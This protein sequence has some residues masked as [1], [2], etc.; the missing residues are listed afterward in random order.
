MGK[1]KV[2]E[3]PEGFEYEAAL[4]FLT[5]QGHYLFRWRVDDGF[6]SKFVRHNDVMAAVHGVEVDSGWTDPGVMRFGSDKHGNWFV[7]FM[8]PRIMDIPFRKGTEVEILRVPLPSTL[9]IGAGNSHYM[10]AMKGREFKPRLKVCKAPFPNVYQSGVICWGNAA[11]PAVHHSHA[12]EAWQLFF[13][14]VFTPFEADDRVRGIP[15]SSLPFWENLARRKARA[16][17]NRALIVGSQSVV[18]VLGDRIREER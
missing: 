6:A 18:G 3:T 7:F 8:P 13:S 10:Y 17:P 1:T 2:M 4:Y 9:L 11:A 5:N 15:G 14:T 16:F 12:G